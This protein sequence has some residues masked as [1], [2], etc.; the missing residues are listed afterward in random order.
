MGDGDG[1]GREFLNNDG[2]NFV[3]FFFIWLGMNGFC[4]YYTKRMSHRI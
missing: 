4:D 3:N 1:F 2:F